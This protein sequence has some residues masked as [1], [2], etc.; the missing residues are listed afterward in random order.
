MDKF[1]SN[2][3]LMHS[4]YYSNVIANTHFN[5][6]FSLI[7]KKPVTISHCVFL[8]PNH[9]NIKNPHY[10]NKKKTTEKKKRH[11]NNHKTEQKKK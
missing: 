6:L 3:V 10:F 7:K 2:A 9:I 5:F 4:E 11:Q 8:F 1:Q